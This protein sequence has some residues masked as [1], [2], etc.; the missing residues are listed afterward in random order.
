M[1]KRLLIVAILFITKIASAQ[2]TAWITQLNEEENFLTA[3][4]S[5]Y[6]T[7][8]KT[9]YASTT[10]T[11]RQFNSSGTALLATTISPGS[12]FTTMNIVKILA[13]PNNELY[14]LGY[15]S[16]SGIREGLLFK[17]SSSLLQSWVRRLP[18]GFNYNYPTPID[19]AIKG[20]DIAVL[21][22][23]NTSAGNASFEL[24]TVSQ[25][26]GNIT[27]GGQSGTNYS[28]LTPVSMAVDAS[29]NVYV[30]GEITTN[31]AIL[32]KY[33]TSLSKVW[34]KVHNMGGRTWFSSIATDVAG[35]VYVAGQG[36]TSSTSNYKTIV[37]KYNSAGALQSSYTSA[38]LVSSNYWPEVG[39]KIKM[40]AA[41][42]LFVGTASNASVQPRI[43]AYKFSTANLATPTYAVTHLLPLS[44]WNFTMT[45]FEATQSGKV[46]FTGS[47]IGTSNL[48]IN[49]VTAKLRA[50]GTLEFT[51][52][53]NGGRCNA[54]IKA[55]PGSYPN[56]E[57]V[58]TGVISN[59]NML[60][61]YTGPGVRMEDESSV[62][63]NIVV[64]TYP[65]PARSVLSVDYTGSSA[66]L[67]LFDLNGRQI[68]T[69]E[70]TG[71][72]T[73]NVTDLP[74]GLY[75]LR[76]VNQEGDTTS[77]K[78]ILE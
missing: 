37:R 8:S 44:Y 30:C 9:P 51:E 14:I 32:I 62:A 76:V 49:Y 48:T 24:R 45:G 74:R 46:F 1:T 34:T 21:M 42:E 3:G 20:S 29:Q 68:L 19:M 54:M 43:M 61:K 59:L 57:F 28:Y 52:V 75:I 13:T 70:I 64:N 38:N 22:R 73:L 50:N 47:N 58:T 4:S 33:N 25:S 78:I 40:T 16:Y 2:T 56:D 66:Q 39:P 10:Y 27:I 77:K 72:L 69:Q 41:G 53:Y 55:I 65:N 6:Y 15:G 67:H 60:I 63:E 31:N 17:L 35:N 11:V 5:R 23:S 71:N 36:K 26:S 7:V 12:P 18:A